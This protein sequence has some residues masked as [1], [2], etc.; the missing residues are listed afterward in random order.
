M[1]F[2]DF[3]VIPP[4]ANKTAKPYPPPHDTIKKIFL[5]AGNMKP[6]LHR[7]LMHLKTNRIV[8]LMLILVFTLAIPLSPAAVL[9][10]DE[11][12]TPA[13]TL[14]ADAAVEPP[15]EPTAVPTKRERS[16]HR[17]ARRSRTHTQ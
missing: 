13:P 10:Q 12:A 5:K 6:T 17:N 4:P 1:Y 3:V 8:L 7:S 2:V 16:P 11:T 14:P 15:G 9:A